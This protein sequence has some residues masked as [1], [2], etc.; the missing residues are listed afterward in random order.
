MIPESVFWAHRNANGSFSPQ[1]YDG[2]IVMFR[3]STPPSFPGNKF[4]DPTLG[5]SPFS[6]SI[7]TREIPGTHW[8]MVTEPNIRILAEAIKQSLPTMEK[9]S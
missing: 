5:W 1:S 9:K 4:D 2:E 6:K 7:V 3:A 8:T